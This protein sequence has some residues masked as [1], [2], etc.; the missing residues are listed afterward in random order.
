MNGLSDLDLV[1]QAMATTTRTPSH[2]GEHTSRTTHASASTVPS[3]LNLPSDNGNTSGLPEDIERSLASLSE[4]DKAALGPLLQ[5]LLHGEE[6][7]GSEGL[8][9][10]LKQFDAADDVADRLE[11][12]LDSLLEGLKGVEGSLEDVA[13]SGSGS[14]SSKPDTMAVEAK[15]AFGNIADGK[16]EK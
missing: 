9:D 16:Q 6:S 4:G 8:E 3:D 5:M 12:K 7:N 15:E 1:A 14:A 13:Q 11:G 2:D 10:L